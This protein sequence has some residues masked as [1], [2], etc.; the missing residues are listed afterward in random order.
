MGFFVFNPRIKS[1]TLLDNYCCP[2]LMTTPSPSRASKIS[3]ISKSKY[4]PRLLRIL[5]A[6]QHGRHNDAYQHAMGARL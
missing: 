6:T 1:L 4:L 5:P 3:T 2:K